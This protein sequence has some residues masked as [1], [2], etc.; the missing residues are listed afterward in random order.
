MFLLGNLKITCLFLVLLL[1]IK[2]LLKIRFW[3]LVSI[4]TSQSRVPGGG[5][6]WLPNPS[7]QL[8]FLDFLVPE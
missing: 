5:L 4:V 1:V 7:A 8:F 2:N 3:V 6:V